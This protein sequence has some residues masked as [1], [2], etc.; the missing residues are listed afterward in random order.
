MNITV[1]NGPNLNL[2]GTRQP[3][4]YGTLTLEQIE[5]RIDGW[6]GRMGV[7]VSTLQSNDESE[8]VDMIQKAG[9][10]SDALVINAGGFT[11]TSVA[12]ADAVASIDRPV[13]EVHLSDIHRRE[14]YRQV[15]LIEP[16][17]VVQIAGRGATGYRD[18]MRHLVN[19]GAMP[20]ETI[21]YG[22]HPRNIGDLRRAPES[23]RLVVLVHGGYW[24]GGWDRDQLDS[25]AISLTQ[26]GFD[27]FNVEYRLDPPWP[28]S[29]HD[30]DMAI[31]SIG[32]GYD[33]VALLGH[34]A[35]G[36]LAIWRHTRQ[37]VDIC[38]GLAPVTDL[39]IVDDVPATTQIV[40]AGGPA[41]VDLS[42][43]NI[44]LFHGADDTDVSPQH[45]QREADART[46][47]LD[48]IGHFD[49]ID[50]NRPHWE[51]VVSTL[52]D[53]MDV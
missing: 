21:R 37:P 50:P 11:H 46:H 45:S 28:G 12:I 10:S 30:I 14:P 43:P 39:S 22:P 18:A 52:R 47:L 31:R 33:T 9:R 53:H 41:R 34:S 1:I 27:T 23:G 25:A 2:L 29:G 19:R 7:T 6:A 49:I 32:P 51:H 15:S 42:S 24:F 16:N 4:V 8:L 48:G 44:V 35:G 5:E 26:G 20:F 40:S 36:F 3:E 17:A 38:V 13:A